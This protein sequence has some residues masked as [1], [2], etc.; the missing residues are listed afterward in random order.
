M[1]R[2][3]FKT[4]GGR[5]LREGCHTSKRR[6]TV[7]AIVTIALMLPLLIFSF[8]AG[9]G[10]ATNDEP[11]LSI[12][13]KN[14][15]GEFKYL[16]GTIADI[17]QTQIIHTEDSVSKRSSSTLWHSGSGDSQMWN[18]SVDERRGSVD[19]GLAG[20]KYEH[21]DELMKETDAR[22][23]YPI[24]WS[25]IPQEVREKIDSG[26]EVIVCLSAG[27]RWGRGEN[28][29]ID[30]LFPVG[31]DWIRTGWDEE[32]IGANAEGMMIVLPFSYNFA[33]TNQNDNKSEIITLQGA[34][35][36]IW[37]SAG[38][39][40]DYLVQAWDSMPIPA[41]GYGYLSVGIGE[42]QPGMAKFG[43]RYLYV[44]SETGNPAERP[45]NPAIS[46]NPEE[47]WWIG[48]LRMSYEGDKKDKNY[49]VLDSSL[50]DKVIVTQDGN[51]YTGSQIE[52]GGKNEGFYNMQSMS[53]RFL[54]PVNIEFYLGDGDN[55]SVS[56]AKYNSS[57]RP[58]DEINLEFNVR[59]T[60][61]KDVRPAYTIKVNGAIADRGQLLIPGECD[62]YVSFSF[63]MPD[64]DA[65]VE[66][67]V[68]PDGADPAETDLTDN[69]IVINIESA[70]LLEV[71]GDVVLEYN[72]LEQTESF[73][74]GRMTATLALPRYSNAR[75]TGP[76]D[77]WIT[78]SNETPHLYHDFRVNGIYDDK[79]TIDISS[80]AATI[81]EDIRIR[82]TIIRD[83][84]NFR[85]DPLA[86]RYGANFLHSTLSPARTGVV[87]AEGLVSRPF[88]YTVR[89]SYR[90]YSEALGT[91][92]TI[93]ETETVDG[94][95]TARFN[96]ISNRKTIV[97]EVY[98]GK[99]SLNPSQ[100][101]VNQIDGN[102][103]SN[104]TKQLWW[105]SEK[106]P[107]DVLR[108]MGDR[109]PN[110][111]QRNPPPVNGQ[112]GRF[113]TNQ[114]EAGIK[115]AIAAGTGG[116]NFSMAGEYRADRDNSRARNYDSGGAKKA[117]FA[118]DTSYSS[119]PYP[120]RSGY[121]FNPAGTYEF[122]VNT[123]I[124]SD[125]PYE[126]GEHEQL[127]DAMIASFRY[128]SNMVYVNASGQ[129]VTIG[130]A[131]VSKSGTAYAAAQ[132]NAKVGGSPLFDID[133]EREHSLDSVE[134]LQHD[135]TEAGADAR[136]RRV[137]EGYTESGTRSS[138]TNYKYIEF[139]DED[140][141][142]Y[143]ITETTTVRITVNPDNQRVYTHP[144]MRNGDYSVRASFANTNLNTLSSLH[145]NSTIRAMTLTGA[146]NLD[147][148][149]IRV[150]GS[151]YDDVR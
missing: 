18:W 37:D 139:V 79:V 71:T 70:G 106:I 137:L 124:Y 86:G 6:K 146:G 14:K 30:N 17:S 81:A 58:G 92:I 75:W 41:F 9:T 32:L 55:L 52:I 112:F 39:E 31:A 93:W 122:T 74:L 116:K 73:T 48:H 115:F 68:N 23:R 132:G 121:F 102:T 57:A 144:Q 24:P 38:I 69:A 131:L 87:T 126:T 119:I 62:E 109:A 91:Y 136:Y 101:P 49:V 97:V 90:E 104:M 134:E 140:A 78:V 100:A 117:V 5:L 98:N 7:S 114:N 12:V 59:S 127:V 77:G 53:A 110:F 61:L 40:A 2:T 108:P 103:S 4:Q 150:V 138:M 120:I 63:T 135:Y 44:I 56:A 89:Y 36:T 28:L 60:F 94:V 123:Q 95:V 141:M 130:G 129:A 47:P 88:S 113:F 83:H 96:S 13:F 43:E 111:A 27:E 107:L 45:L 145:Y 22:M 26:R 85:D 16:D 84:G 11:Q 46:S 66:F 99:A 118:S 143:L 15:N 1:L 82:A 128:E 10:S 51:D 25:Q 29:D 72:V 142:V 20:M 105:E 42:K 65:A 3:S 21:F 148:I 76:A 50:A 151:M 54:F 125:T 35:Q 147:S 33:R 34:A 64:N 8:E 80:N 149:G 133:V 19:I 67:T